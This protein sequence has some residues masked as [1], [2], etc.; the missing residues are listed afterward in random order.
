MILDFQQAKRILR[1]SGSSFPVE[2]VNGCYYGKNS[3]ELLKG[4]YYKYCGQRFWEFL[5]GESNLYIDLIKPLASDAKRHTHEYQ[6]KHANTLNKITRD[7]FLRFCDESGK[8][9][10][11]NLVKINSSYQ[12]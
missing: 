7:F 3:G 11:V 4:V 12:R 2:F 5:S 6:T 8:I 9:D 10:W 1:T